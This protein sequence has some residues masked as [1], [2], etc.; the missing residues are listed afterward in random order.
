MVDSAYK[1]GQEAALL[2]LGQFLAESASVARLAAE[3]PNER[4]PPEDQLSDFDR[5]VL[6]GVALAHEELL[7][8]VEA[9]VV[10]KRPASAELND[11]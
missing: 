10:P 7:R 9:G 1:R 6:V 3:H 11:G 2:G 5:G 4:R 8:H